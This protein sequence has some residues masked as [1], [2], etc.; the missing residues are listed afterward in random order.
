MTINAIYLG[1]K[2]EDYVSKAT[3]KAGVARNL[4]VLTE[5]NDLLEF[6][7][8]SFDK[9]T[10]LVDIQQVPSGTP[11]AIEVDI[12]PNRYDSNRPRVILRGYSVLERSRNK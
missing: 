9:Q 7:Y 6:G 8:D 10:D 4:K 12:A 3:G 5:D 2:E 1:Y 11:I